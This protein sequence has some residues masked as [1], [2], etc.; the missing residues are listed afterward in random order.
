MSEAGWE[1]QNA[2]ACEYNEYNNAKS[3]MKEKQCR[4]NQ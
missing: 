3:E 2:R 1:A 4:E